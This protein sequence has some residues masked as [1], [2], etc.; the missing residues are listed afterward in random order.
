MT[1]I[2][3]KDKTDLYEIH[4]NGQGTESEIVPITKTHECCD[5]SY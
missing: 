1:R 2:V 3:G 4:V 5:M